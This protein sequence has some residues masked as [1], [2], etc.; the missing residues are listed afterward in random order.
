MR[1]KHV[2]VHNY[3]SIR[4]IELHCQSLVVLLGPNDHGKS[5]ILGAIEFALSSS[6]KLSAE[7][8]FAFRSSDDTDLWVELEFD[9]L[10]EQERTTFQKYVRPTGTVKIRKEARSS[11][12]NT[13]ETGY[14][15]Y[16][17]E[18]A[19][20][21]L[22]G[23]GVQKLLKREDVEKEESATIPALKKLLESKG[24][25]TK[26]QV[27]EF[28]TEYRTEHA[29]EIT[30]SETLE[31][32]PLLGLKNVASGV[33]PD[34]YLLPAIRDLSDETKVA[35]TTMFGRLLQRAVQEMASRDPQFVELRKNLESLVNSLNASAAAGATRPTQ[36]QRMEESID[37]ELKAWGVKVSIEVTPPELEKIF[38][39][40]TQLHVDD[41]L[42]TRL[43]ERVMAFSVP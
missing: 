5:N 42:R 39:L 41:G 8:F 11:D 40:G 35:K 26:A 17:S 30:L 27:E 13:V 24:K 15:G 18:P 9:Q 25:I 36:L 3:R 7:D 37:T 32:A 4:E 43:T 14:R 29:A 6:S 16:A 1:I 10:T 12:N 38:E 31:D 22:K 19:E 20:W 23:S 2:R 33:L 28:Q 34:F 21:W